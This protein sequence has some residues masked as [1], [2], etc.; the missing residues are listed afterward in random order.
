[1]SDTRE[2]RDNRIWKSFVWHDG[3]CFFVST[4][5][6]DFD[7][8]VGTVRGEETLTWEYDWDKSERGELIGQS[9]GICDHQ[10]ICRCL[11]NFG[12]IPD[13]D[14]ERYLRFRS[15]NYR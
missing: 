10:A 5:S 15:A 2:Q 8:Y 3:K 9:G 14:D 4:L 13:D 7:T 6:R 12:E 1:M 11:I